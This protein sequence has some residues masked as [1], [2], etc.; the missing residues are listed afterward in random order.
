[1]HALSC[2]W[3][4]EPASQSHLSQQAGGGT[5]TGHGFCIR[6]SAPGL[7]SGLVRAVWLPFEKC[8]DHQ[9][10]GMAAPSSPSLS[11]C[12]CPRGWTTHPWELLT[13]CHWQSRPEIMKISLKAHIK[14]YSVTFPSPLSPTWH[15]AGLRNSVVLSFPLLFLPKSCYVAQAGPSSLSS[16]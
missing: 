9:S 15:V 10:N 14:K 13:V 12:E 3:S 8:S 1:M 11:H 5:L 2:A 16:F 7:L 6:L 4:G